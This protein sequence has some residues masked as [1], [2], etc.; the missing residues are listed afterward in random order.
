MVEVS[1]TTTSLDL[2]NIRKGDEI[3]YK[4]GK[5]GIVEKIQII[6]AKGRKKYF[7]KI[8]DEGIIFIAK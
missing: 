6:C 7:Y 2:D 1:Q 8:K 5:L 3:A 4:N